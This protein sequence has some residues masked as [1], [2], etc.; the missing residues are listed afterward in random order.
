V[1]PEVIESMVTAISTH[2]ADPGIVGVLLNTLGKLAANSDNHRALD[3]SGVVGL[4]IDLL[5]AHH[6]INDPRVCEGIAAI[7]LPLSFDQTYVKTVLSDA[8]VIPQ[9]VNIIK[10]YAKFT[11]T[12]VGSPM[13]WPPENKMDYNERIAQMKAD[14]I[15]AEERN[16]K[17]PRLAQMCV[18]SLANLACDNDPDEFGNSSV[19]RIVQSGG[20]EALGQLMSLHPDNPRLLEDAICALSNMAFVSDTIQLA[21][22]RSCMDTVCSAATNFNADSYLFQMTLRAI[23]NLTRCDE[24]IMRAVGYGVI[25]GMV[26]TRRYIET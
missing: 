8:N 7:I 21:I 12:Y 22:G 20:I 19:T 18:Q 26:R 16:K 23:G 5:T 15:D 24:N 6:H 1:K 10:K 4:A 2:E 25:H 11:T 17:L 9:L 3:S 13:S 14:S